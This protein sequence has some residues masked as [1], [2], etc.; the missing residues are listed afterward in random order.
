MDWLPVDFD[1]HEY[2]VEKENKFLRI[3][4]V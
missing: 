2:D 3:L 4:K 1:T